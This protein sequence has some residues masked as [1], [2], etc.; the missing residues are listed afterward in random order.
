MS[1]IAFPELIQRVRSGDELAIQE[2]VNN[3]GDALKR[4]IRFSLMDSKLKRV[5]SESDICQS[6]IMRLITGIWAGS[7]DFESSEQLNGLLKRM[8]KNK[9]VDLTRYWQAQ[10]RDIRRDATTKNSAEQLENRQQA[11]PSKILADTEM[12]TKIKNEMNER[13]L[14]IMELRQS[15]VNWVTIAESLDGVSSPDAVR[16][17]YSRTIERIVKE[18]DPFQD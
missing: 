11:T 18:F 3:Y 7:Y 9:I 4:E 17:Q 14:Q 5:V 16:K 13:E 8:V 12:V 15:Q 1:R 2:L 6:V 10:R